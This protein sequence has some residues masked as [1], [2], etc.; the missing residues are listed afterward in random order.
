[1]YAASSRWCDHWTLTEY[2]RIV[3]AAA[4]VTKSRASAEQACPE[5]VPAASGSGIA[6]AR[7]VGDEIQ[8]EDA[9]SWRLVLSEGQATLPLAPSP[10][11]A[12]VNRSM[13]RQDGNGDEA[14][15]GE[16]SEDREA[17]RE[18][19]QTEGR[20]KSAAAEVALKLQD[21]QEARERR[22][23]RWMKRQVLLAPGARKSM[24]LLVCPELER[25]Q[26]I[27]ALTWNPAY[28][29]VLRM[30]VQTPWGKR[31]TH[32]N[33]S[34]VL[35][36]SGSI[37]LLGL[38]TEPENLS[39][40]HQPRVVMG[41][42]DTSQGG[43]VVAACWSHAS[44]GNFKVSVAMSVKGPS[45]EDR[46]AAASTST[47]NRR[48]FLHTVEQCNKV[49]EKALERADT[50]KPPKDVRDTRLQIQVHVFSHRGGLQTFSAQQHGFFRGAEWNACILDSEHQRAQPFLDGG[51]H[52]AKVE[53]ELDKEDVPAAWH[54]WRSFQ[55]SGIGLEEDIVQLKAQIFKTQSR[56]ILAAEQA[57]KHSKSERQRSHIAAACEA[58]D[59]AQGLL[60]KAGV[61]GQ[62]EPFDSFTNEAFANMVKEW[63]RDINSSQMLDQSPASADLASTTAVETSDRGSISKLAPMIQRTLTTAKSI[64]RLPSNEVLIEEALA[65]RFAQSI[66]QEHQVRY[67]CVRTR[68]N[69]SF[70]RLS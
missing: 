15:G 55:K 9:S 48:L 47:E 6:S 1:M 24:R 12:E 46:D 65:L 62:T 30:T 36:D 19:R 39:V 57:L 4:E 32:L 33:P 18:V 64:S 5:A 44:S 63:L 34:I 69:L 53:E 49:V 68:D 7:P 52:M 67:R 10:L 37:N 54:A 43:P 3:T 50:G 17:D 14:H 16:G 28:S 41:F 42:D 66:A 60:V 26:M 61:L 58:W 31:A 51:V 38:Q 56:L 40:L 23:H 20:V 70:S 27:V 13:T 35:Q 59:Q 22:R 25:Q 29:L 45:K 11:G 2:I 21:L 8:V